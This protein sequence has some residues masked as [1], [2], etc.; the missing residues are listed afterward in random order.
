MSTHTKTPWRTTKEPAQN[1]LEKGELHY[2]I[3]W[4]DCGCAAHVFRPEDAE[5]IVRC[6]NSHDGLVAALRATREA[7]ITLAALAG[8]QMNGGVP[9]AELDTQARAALAA[10]NREAE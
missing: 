3:F 10:A 4:N 2:P 9:F 6:V 7:M 5:H 1:E 8:R